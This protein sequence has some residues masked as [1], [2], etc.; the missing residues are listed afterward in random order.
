MSVCHSDTPGLKPDEP[1]PHTD[2][3][4]PSCTGETGETETERVAA[5][6]L[7]HTDKHNRHGGRESASPRVHC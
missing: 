5:T 6:C 4:T 3:Q 7:Q 1:A 2:T